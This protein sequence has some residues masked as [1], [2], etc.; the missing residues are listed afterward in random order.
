MAGAYFRAVARGLQ[1]TI[2][3][4]T[5]VFASDMLG[6]IL[7][8]ILATISPEVEFAV[9]IDS[10]LA[11]DKVTCKAHLVFMFSPKTA[12]ALLGTLAV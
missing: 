4:S 11:V 8:G 10:E 12:Q 6:D 9:V 1:M 3:Y 7:D 2:T 5:P